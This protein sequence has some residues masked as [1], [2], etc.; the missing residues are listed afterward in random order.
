MNI[1][2]KTVSAAS[3]DKDMKSRFGFLYAL[4]RMRERYWLT[5]GK[6]LRLRYAAM[7]VVCVVL[8]ASIAVLGQRDRGDAG[9]IAVAKID[10]RILMPLHEE[11]VPED[12]LAALR[13]RDAK[14]AELQANN[15]QPFLSEI[16]KDKVSRSMRNAPEWMKK[17][18]P[19]VQKTVSIESGQT[20]AGVL[21]K[22]GLVG[23]DAYEAVEAL[24]AHFD[25][26]RVKPGQK[27]EVHFGGV[28][29]P[30]KDAMGPHA[31]PK[32]PVKTIVMALSP[33]KEIKVTRDEDG[34]FQATLLEKELERNVY[35]RFAEIE[36]SLY[37]SAARSQIPSG[38]IAD[39]IRVYS[40][41]VDFQRDIRQGDKV[42]VLYERFETPDGDYGKNGNILFANLNIG[43][44]D[45][46]IYRFEMDDGRVDYFGPDGTSIRKTLMKTPID[47]ARM[48][49][50]FGM[51]RHPV[52]G[53]NKMHKGVDFAAPTGTPIY[54]AGDGVV[55]FVGRRGGYGKY[56]RLRHNA[57]LKTAYAHMSRYKKGIHAGQ[58][59]KQG[60]V[61]GYVGSTGRSTGPHLHYEVI[62][63]GQ[64]KNPRSVNVPTG[65]TLKGA[66]MKR[67]KSM[68]K[69]VDQ[70]YAS[71]TRGIEFAA[72]DHGQKGKNIH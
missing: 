57:K 15:Y 68:I 44:R 17:A 12:V 53:Y 29:L 32:A 63:N 72:R 49:S 13:A 71:L 54:A 41:N 22:A 42:E 70:E 18:Q 27:L 65:E 6:K 14:E 62:V 66:E 55:D 64:Q 48:S 10:T 43:G 30:D 36:T 47:G 21:Q 25:P 51:R 2:F 33:V 11:D 61:I 50:G 19:P 35:G 46:P 58:R 59:V 4:F 26:R 5:R 52:L 8:V 40:W 39:M 56:I 45:T 3:G 60:D 28:D 23:G 24:S 34:V 9:D 31:K 38:I 20:I 1:H 69:G 67:F 7:I 37:G 16:L